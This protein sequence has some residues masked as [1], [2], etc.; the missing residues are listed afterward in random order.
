MHPVIEQRAALDA[1]LQRG[2]SPLLPAV[3][4]AVGSLPIILLLVGDHLTGIDD[5]Q[6]P[7]WRKEAIRLWA[8]WNK[9]QQTQI[10]KHSLVFVNSRQ[11]YD[12]LRPLIPNLFE[13]HTTTLNATDFFEREDTCDSPPYH[14]LYAGR[15]DRGK[16]LFEMVE[17]LAIL[18]NQGEDVVLD[19]V[20]WPLKDDNVLEEM[21]AFAREQGVGDRMIYHGYKV[22]GPELFSC[23][24]KADLYIIASKSSEGFPRTIWEAMA[25][26][27]PVVATRVGSIPHFLEG[28]AELCRPGNAAELAT[29][30]ARVLNSPGLRQRMIRCGRRLARENTL[31]TQVG[32]MVAHIKEW[33]S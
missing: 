30:L 8:T 11:V 3:A 12:E 24:Q 26:S 10:A 31:E 7:R 13:T 20:G 29:A 33:V 9:H 4:R 27:L 15:L 25:S 18:V 17:A 28:I 6:Q 32:K 22:L 2:P 19:L 23:Y 21:E 5:L 14:L 16:G 1:L